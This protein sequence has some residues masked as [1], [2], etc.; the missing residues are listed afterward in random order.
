MQHEFKDVRCGLFLNIAV[1]KSYL[2]DIIHDTIVGYIEC[3]EDEGKLENFDDWEFTKCGDNTYEDMFMEE[4][5]SQLLDRLNANN[6]PQLEEMEDDIVSNL[7]N[8]YLNKKWI[9]IKF[10]L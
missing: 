3:N 7:V 8:E 10:C 1:N 5:T 9:K 2:Y 4:F 6:Y